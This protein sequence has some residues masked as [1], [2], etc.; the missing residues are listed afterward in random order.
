MWTAALRGCVYFLHGQH[1]VRALSQQESV[2]RAANKACAQAFSAHASCSSRCAHVHDHRSVCRGCA[3][4]TCLSRRCSEWPECSM[5]SAVCMSCCSRCVYINV[6]VAG[7]L[8][9]RI[10]L[11]KQG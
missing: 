3:A 1:G 11:L 5:T 8:P 7:W 4:D 10:L 9:H 6:T 2:Q